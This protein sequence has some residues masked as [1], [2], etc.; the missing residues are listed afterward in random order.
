MTMTTTKNT[1][2]LVATILV[3][4]VSTVT[5]AGAS[6]AARVELHAGALA[7][8]SPAE[9]A[10]TVDANSAT[11]PTIRIDGASVHYIGQMSQTT[12]IN[13]AE[14]AQLSFLYTLVPT[15]IGTF[16]IPALQVS[17]AAGIVTTAPFHA[18]VGAAGTAAATGSPGAAS[19]TEAVAVPTEGPHAFVRIE[20]PSRKLYVGQA[21]PVTIRAYFRAGT[22]ATLDGLP[23]LSSDAFTFSE[24]SDKPA[25]TQIEIRG[26]SYLMATWTAILS[27]AKPSDG[28]LSVELPVELAYRA[29]PRPRAAQGR[30]RLRDL[31]ANDPF[32]SSLF[33][34]DP[35]FNG[36]TDPF[37]DLDSMFDAGAVE[38]HK[39]T[40]RDD[41]GRIVVAELPS[42]GKP[43]GFAGAVG[44]FRLAIDPPGGALRVGEP[45]AVTIRVTGTGNFDR[46]AIPT[47][48]GG[49]D[50]ETFG[51]KTSFAPTA[52]RSL[53]GTKTFLQ[54][55]VPRRA[56]SL[57]LPAMTLA[58]FDPAKG[59]YATA[60][61]QPVA[62]T[63]EA[64]SGGGAADPGLATASVRDPS[65]SP[66]RLEP[67]AHHDTLQP[68]FRQPRFRL[69]AGGLAS[70]T[71][72][73]VLLA[74]WRRDPRIARRRRARR[75]D[76]AIARRCVAM[77]VAYRHRDPAGFFLS[78]REALQTRLG[79]LWHMSPA[80][81]TSADVESRLGARG[82]AIRSVFEHADEMTYASALAE[83]QPLDPWRELVRAEL[84]RL[85]VEP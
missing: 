77:D 19:Q 5:A 18:T 51:G 72:V 47:I 75:L 44:Q 16:D 61:T 14:H 74:W 21:V 37:G 4:A 38:Q 73:L 66:N 6:P 27:P 70:M 85:E 29:A 45:A 17:T 71:A 48:P 39:V 7:V 60:E 78:A 83:T 65:M 32:A 25:Q 50:L 41:A 3:T 55:I 64:A 58:Y 68:L 82:A 26:V 36:D 43:A 22:S 40:L 80:A 56:G 69:A 35:F 28:K 79:A 2:A 63:V 46:V 42:A 59:S 81:V 11:P 20:L 84:A 31:L 9:L 49:P 1:I 52:G 53:T 54:T 67:G 23:H 24:L 33:D 10:V 15:R 12:V 34:N 62:L 57:A 13:G 8:G 76:R 30:S